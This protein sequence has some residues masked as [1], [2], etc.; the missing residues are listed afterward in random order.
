M[1]GLVHC[2]ILYHHTI[3]NLTKCF[4]LRA[5]FHEEVFEIHVRACD[6]VVIF[7]W[8]VPEATIQRAASDFE[9]AA[10]ITG[11]GEGKVKKEA[12]NDAWEALAKR[13]EPYGKT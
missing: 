4:L 8:N 2:V 10:I 5:I 9:M 3:T 6:K 11:W 7:L 12:E 13:M 1:S